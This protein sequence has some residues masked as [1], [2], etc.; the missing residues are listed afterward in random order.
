MT[1]HNNLTTHG[2][3]PRPLAPRRYIV[4]IEDTLG[5]RSNVVAVAAN[6]HEAMLQINEQAYRVV[7][8]RPEKSSR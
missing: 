6:A 2:P 8:A 4:T 5:N 1:D 3:R 7:A